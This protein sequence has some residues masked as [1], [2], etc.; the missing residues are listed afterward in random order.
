MHDEYYE[1]F[2]LLVGMQE[3]L[4]GKHRTGM[5]F[6]KSFKPIKS[7]FSNVP[8]RILQVN[9]GRVR[10]TLQLVASTTAFRFW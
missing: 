9:P 5:Q 10:T 8:V 7:A 4:K 2:P 1:S 6:V 3:L